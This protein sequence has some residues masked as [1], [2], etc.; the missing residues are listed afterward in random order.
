MRACRPTTVLPF[1]AQLLLSA[2]PCGAQATG[3]L[4]IETGNR[5]VYVHEVIDGSFVGDY[6]IDTFAVEVTPQS[7]EQRD[8]ETHFT[9]GL[10]LHWNGRRDPDSGE[11]AMLQD[12]L[13][14]L[15]SR[16]LRQALEPPD[17]TAF[18]EGHPGWTA[19]QFGEH[20]ARVLPNGF[21]MVYDF[22]PVPRDD[23]TSSDGVF[24]LWFHGYLSRPWGIKTGRYEPDGPMPYSFQPEA[25]QAVFETGA[26]ETWG[27]TVF[28]AGIGV[29]Y[30]EEHLI[31]APPSTQGTTRLLWARIGGVEYGGRPTAARSTTWAGVKTDRGANP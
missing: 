12:A 22:G 20:L 19:E 27:I 25:E 1:T 5:W 8:G 17:T 16:A 31:L 28:E 30:V 2:L 3:F 4:P 23:E 18:L 26:G 10:P 24:K 9:L 21:V 15:F 13:G 6:R 29:T 14:N 7:F 11:H